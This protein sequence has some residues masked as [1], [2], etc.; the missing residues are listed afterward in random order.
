LELILELRKYFI[1]NSFR[2]GPKMRISMKFQAHVQLLLPLDWT[3]RAADCRVD[4]DNQQ[5]AIL[6]PEAMKKKTE[7]NVDIYSNNC[8]LS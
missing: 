6:P 4:G 5:P 7:G 2:K 8:V 3:T 1:S